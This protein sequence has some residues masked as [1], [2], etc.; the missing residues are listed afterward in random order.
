MTKIP[1]HLLDS[2][3]KGDIEMSTIEG[4]P[5]L[6]D[7]MTKIGHEIINVISKHHEAG[8]SDAILIFVL[9]TVSQAVREK[10]GIVHYEVADKTSNPFGSGTA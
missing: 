5:E 9:D 7:L 2:I 1:Q 3:A 8:V 6:R 10:S 4:S